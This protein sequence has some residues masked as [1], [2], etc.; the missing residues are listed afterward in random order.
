MS[1]YVRIRGVTY[2]VMD[3]CVCGAIFAVALTPFEHARQHGGFFY[4]PNGHRVGWNK[5]DTEDARIRRERDILKQQIAQRDDS[6]R[7]ERHHRVCAERSAAAYKGQVTKLR[8]R[9]KAGVCP[10][11]NRTFQNLSRHMQTQHPD[12]EDKA[13]ELQVV[14]GG[15]P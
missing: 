14:E 15:K 1:E 2:G 6:L 13:P 5:S 11:C 7:E 12:F 10:C 8:K 4:C 9:A 3:C